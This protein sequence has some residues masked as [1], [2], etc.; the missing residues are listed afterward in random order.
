MMTM[1]TKVGLRPFVPA[2]IAAAVLAACGGSGDGETAALNA[3]PAYLGAISEASYDGASND[4]LT[5]GLGATGMAAAAP[6]A[7]ADPLKPTAAELRRTAIHTNYRAMLDMTAAGGYGSLYGP[8]VDAQGKVTAGEGKVAG[9]EYI[10][11]AD[12]GTGR[13][14]VTLMVQVPASF[15]PAKPCMITATTS[16]SRGVYGGISTGEWG[17]K[18]GCAVAYSDKGTGGAPH[19][20]QNDTVPLIDGTRTTATAAGKNAAF[21]AGL[22]ATELAAFNTATPNRFAFKHAHS[23][24]NSEKDWGTT[25]LQAV[26]FGYYVLNQRYGNTNAAGQRLKTLTPANTI[27]IASSISNG[28]GAAIAAA[29]QDTQGLISG[30]AVSEPA[31]ELPANPGVTVRRGS[32]DLAVTGKTLVDFT[33][34]ANLYQAC[35]SLAPSVSASPFAAAYAAGFASAGLPIAPNRCA[36]LKTAG[37]LSASTTATQAEE[38]LQKLRDYGWEPESNDLHASLAAFEVAPAVAVTFANSLSRSSVKDHLCGFSYAAASAVG[39]VIPL[40]PAALPGMF[41]TGNGVPPAGGIQLINNQSKLGPARD[42][43]SVSDSGVLDWNTP[44]ALCLRN[45]VTGSDAAAKKLQAGLDETRRNGNLRGKPTVIVHGR[46][47]ALLPVSHTSRPYAALNKKVEGAASKLSYVEV[48]NAQHFDSF[49]G[50][51]TVLPGY[52]T[53]Y[54]PLHVY[55]NHALDAVY[56]HLANGKALPASQVV[57]TV[58]RGGTPGSAPAITAANVPALAMTPAAANAIAI[59]AGAISIPD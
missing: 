3:E 20:L 8:N 6:P 48:A 32:T 52:D 23:G 36:A 49:I 59:T 39:A 9:T 34:Y 10:A 14:N 31:L 38:A 50:L 37:L 27:V 16:G 1:S 7:F 5:A 57:R 58:P 21:N 17:L 42:F 22:S 24:Q 11:F 13:K 25:T 45:L 47:D 4:L 15:N 56:E 26:E 30:V 54:V 19:D 43:L 2:A 33:T 55:L 44:G 12:D 53:R 40:A 29:E 46:A 41:A 28:G 51:P 35:A 18:R